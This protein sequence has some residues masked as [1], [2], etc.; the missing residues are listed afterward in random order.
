M[1][2]NEIKTYGSVILLLVLY[3]YGGWREE[4][5]LRSFENSV[6]DIWT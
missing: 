3:G 6:E 1:C 4:H 5:R 2:L